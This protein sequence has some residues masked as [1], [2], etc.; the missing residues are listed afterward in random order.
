MKKHAYLIMAHNEFELLY[1]LLKE[2]DD[3]RNDIFLHVDKKTKFLDEKKLRSTVVSSE[4]FL[5]PR[6]KVNWGT[7]SQIKCELRLM[8]AASCRKYHYYHLISGTD[9][10]IKSQD[11]IHRFLENDNSLYIS[12][13]RNGEPGYDFLDKIRYYYP[14]LAFVGKGEFRGN[15]IKDKFGRK[16]G[17]WQLRLTEIQRDNKV[18]RTRKHKGITF[19]KGD[20]WFS[21]THDFV[22][23]ILEK[24]NKILRSYF[25]TDGADEIFI[26]TLAMNSIFAK[27]VKNSSLREIDWQKGTPYEYRYSEIEELKSSENLFVRKVSFERDP[28]LIDAL[29]KHI[30]DNENVK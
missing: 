4:L 1:R 13:H 29:T 30:H 9:F 11:Y 19:Y 22:E 12:C 21:I 18:D 23:A 17:Y 20:Q 8:K 27:R 25:W 15:T 2:L 14:L 6:M 7:V 26:Q 5:I 3:P 16:L 24:K 28:N 10:P